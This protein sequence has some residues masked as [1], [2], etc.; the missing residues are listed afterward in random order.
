MLNRVLETSTNENREFNNSSDQKQNRSGMA[1][2]SLL[3]DWISAAMN[4]FRLDRRTHRVP[5]PK[6]TSE[7]YIEIHLRK[8]QG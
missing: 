6:L 1:R 8:E 5:M 4:T 3:A 7:L 2:A